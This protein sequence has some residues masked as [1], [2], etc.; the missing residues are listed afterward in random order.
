MKRRHTLGLLLTAA[1]LSACGES[2]PS[3][4]ITQAPKAE[5]AGLR[6]AQA[7]DPSAFPEPAGR[8]LEQIASEFDTNGP[9]AAIATSVFR[10]GP[11]RLAFGIL[12][13]ELKF[14]YGETVVYIAPQ[15]S[16][17]VQGPIAAPA[18]VLITQPR[19]RSKQAASEKDPFAAVYAAELDR[20]EPGVYQ[21]LVVSDTGAGGRVAAG[22]DFEVKSAKADRIPDVGERAPKTATDTLASLKG[23]ETLLDTRIPAAPEL[24]SKSLD[25]VLGSKPVALLFSTPQLC[26]S[27]VCGPVTDIALQMRAEFGDRVEFIHQEVY[28]DNAVAKGLRPPLERFN[29]E[30][31][32]WLFTIRADGRIAARLEGS[33]GVDAFKKAVEAA[34]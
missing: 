21:A 1:V 23:D 13:A 32:P 29:L 7:P 27:R 6:A 2:E 34:L 16:T 3:D 10:T 17:E 20:A 22:V 19:Y 25:Q 4:P 33:F 12:D 5:Q 28:V 18:D 9:Q 8:T 11:N 30:T 14:V 26:Q 24:H 15:G 31:E